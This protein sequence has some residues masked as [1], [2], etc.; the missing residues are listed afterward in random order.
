MTTAGSPSGGTSPSETI[1]LI[2]KGGG[3]TGALMRA[4]DWSKSPL[5]SPLE[6]PQSLRSVVGLLLNSRF[7]MFVAWGD[8][9]GFLY[10][11]A[12]A[13][14]LGAKHPLA[15]GARFRDIWSEIWDDISPL[16]DAAMAGEASYRENL[17][18]VMNRK[19]FDEQTW[20]TF[21]YSPVRDERGSVAGMFCA[22]SETTDTVLAQR[23]A[24][25]ENEKLVEMF[26]QAPGFMALTR[27]PEHIF[28]LTNAAFV[29]L[30]GNRDPL[31]KPVRQALPEVG[32]QGFFELLDRVYAGGEPFVGREIPID[33]RT[34]EEGGIERRL[35][36][37]VYQPVRD[38]AGSVG[39]IFV[40]GQ[41]VTERVRAEAALREQERATAGERA[42]AEADAQYRAYFKNTAE[43]LFVVNVLEDGGFS[44][45]DLNPAHEAG[46]GLPL[47]EVHGKRI[48]EILP[49]A[50]AEQVQAHYRHVL[51]TGEVYAYRETFELSGEPTFWDTVL[52]PVRDASGKIFRIIGSSR[53]LTGQVA[54]EE[55][56]R[57][58][59]K[60]EALGQLTG[61][62]AHDFNN[63]L[64]PIVGALDMLKR[65]TD[66][67]RSLRLID[68][69]LTSAERARTLITRLLS[70]ARK[71]R[72]EGRDIS[73]QRLL[74]GTVDLLER[75]IGPAIHLQ[76]DLPPDD[77][78]VHVDPNQLELALLNLAVNARDAMPEGGTL[79]IR[80][81]REKVVGAHPAGLANGEYARI[82]VEDNGCGMDERTLRMA[83]E[84][85]YSTK[86]QGKGTGLGLSMVHGLAAQSQ[87]GLSIASQVGRGTTVELWL[88]LGSGE[89][90]GPQADPEAIM[91]S[92]TPLKILLVDDE[93]LVRAATADMLM[94]VGHTVYQAHSGQGA[95]KLFETDPSYD[96]LV[97]DYA[98]P[99]MSGAALIRRIKEI[100]PAMPALLVTG[101]AS[102]TRDV[103]DDVPRIEKPFRAAE[104]IGRIE[105]LVGASRASRNEPA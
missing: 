3:E 105:E 33:L 82:S 91:D 70:F 44:I 64:T 72:L 57:Q 60:M 46:I 49:P 69:G 104:L 71:Q 96:L 99:L 10:N 94:D 19:G 45:E 52:V 36:D 92:V 59:Q 81:A 32:G 4:H 48:D 84:P 80:G 43:A 25:A 21:S 51:S 102:A 63:L 97:T 14:I 34:S 20:F 6:W 5:G 50:L 53:D 24:A 93:D 76:L 17:P 75:S 22:C 89:P 100:D 31:G 26:R 38:D 67:A 9:L 2:L 68:G 28:E 85:F 11:D 79:T 56:L 42:R 62:I 39:G 74:R 83:V 54:A 58:A 8:E 16:I 29:E 98:M 90:V 30:V 66:D 73:L 95:I 35:V 88:P 15:I 55:R 78:S 41:D 101:Y 1:D 61:G 40:Q 37:F 47:A 12:Y 13:E 18:L 77:L 65:K 7:P 27:G 23:R 103:P 87:G 86:E